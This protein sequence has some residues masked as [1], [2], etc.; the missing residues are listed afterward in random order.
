[1]INWEVGK[2]YKTRCGQK[3]IVDTLWPIES[4]YPVVFTNKFSC[5]LDGFNTSPNS[6]SIH[7]IIG[8]WDEPISDPYAYKSPPPNKTYTIG[9]VPNPL[10][11]FGRMKDQMF[12]KIFPE[13][14][15]S[16]SLKLFDE[17]F[18][19]PIQ[20][21]SNK[22]I[23][24]ELKNA[25]AVYEEIRNRVGNALMLTR[26]NKPDDRR[27]REGLATVKQLRREMSQDIIKGYRRCRSRIHAHALF[28]DLVDLRASD[29]PNDNENTR[30][31]YE[32]V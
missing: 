13:E 4:D 31:W 16:A 8:E 1:M 24:E 28:R 17:I 7:D 23:M 12:D 3:F 19:E 26:D 10:P 15:K 5:D 32:R 9:K 30:P 25:V 11:M 6:P 2:A 27:P 18:S 22:Q 20:V 14:A 21:F 29:K